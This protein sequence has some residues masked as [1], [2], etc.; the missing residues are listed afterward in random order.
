MKRT[1][2][3]AVESEEKECNLENMS[4]DMPNIHKTVKFKQGSNE[5][6]DK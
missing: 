2:K 3:E 6:L 4:K 5:N 1:R